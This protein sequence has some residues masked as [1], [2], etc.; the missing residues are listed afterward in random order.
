MGV[1][2]IL[3]PCDTYLGF[4]GSEVAGFWDILNYRG[5][6]WEVTLVE[7]SDAVF[8]EIKETKWTKRYSLWQ[9]FP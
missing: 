5:I 3:G 7:T 2:R 9:L 4:P 1:R 8:V 6:F